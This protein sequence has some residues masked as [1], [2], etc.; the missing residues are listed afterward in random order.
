M[1]QRK[2]F[3]KGKEAWKVKYQENVSQQKRIKTVFYHYYIKQVVQS[4]FLARWGGL[5]KIFFKWLINLFFHK[6][7]IVFSVSHTT[8]YKT[9]HFF[10]SS[11]KTCL[12][13]EES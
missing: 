4:S 11:S 3:I 5:N 13:E 2:L 8:C 1:W 7:E 12:F 6:A 10:N 9:V